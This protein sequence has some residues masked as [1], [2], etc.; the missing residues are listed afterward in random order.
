MAHSRVE[1][2][3]LAAKF[4]AFS[5]HWNPR[6]IA[7]LNGQ[8]VRLARLKGSFVWH[9]HADADELF[10]V[11]SGNLRMGLR[12]AGAE[13]FVEVHPGELIVIPRGTDHC[14]QAE[15]EVQVL[16]FEPAGTLNT[17]NVVDERTRRRLDTV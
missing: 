5:D 16:L 7:R 15:D 12:E 17:G 6:I 1:P 3:N 10:L 2:V 14:P 9:H 13:R 4:A 11:V 8:E